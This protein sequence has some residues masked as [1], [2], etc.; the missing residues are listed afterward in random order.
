MQRSQ[1]APL[2]PL[3]GTSI[4]VENKTKYDLTVDCRLEGS[5]L[6][7]TIAQHNDLGAEIRR[8]SVIDQPT[9]AVTRWVEKSKEK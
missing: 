6:V 2:A 3:F 7:F 9:V 4:N 8:E 5:R 1:L